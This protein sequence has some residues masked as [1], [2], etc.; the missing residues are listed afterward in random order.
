[1]DEAVQHVLSRDDRFVEKLLNAVTAHFTEEEKYEDFVLTEFCTQLVSIENP[2]EI[3]PIHHSIFWQILKK[4]AAQLPS[5][6][7]HTDFSIIYGNAEQ[8]LHFSYYYGIIVLLATLVHKDLHKMIRHA[9]GIPQVLLVASLQREGLRRFMI[10]KVLVNIE[11]SVNVHKLY[12]GGYINGAVLQD[13]LEQRYRATGEN[14]YETPPP[15]HP[16]WKSKVPPC[17]S[18]G[19]DQAPKFPERAAPTATWLHPIASARQRTMLSAVYSLLWGN[20]ASLILDV[21]AFLKTPDVPHGAKCRCQSRIFNI[22][23]LISLLHA[24]LTQN[25]DTRALS[26]PAMRLLFNSPLF[27]P[28]LSRMETIASNV[29][30]WMVDGSA[31]SLLEMH[32]QQHEVWC[33]TLKHVMTLN[34]PAFSESLSLEN[35]PVEV[36]IT[37]D[38]T[39]LEAPVL[40]WVITEV[41]EWPIQLL[42]DHLD[43]NLSF[44]HW[45]TKLRS[46]LSNKVRSNF[47]AY[48]MEP[49]VTL[50]QLEHSLM[51]L[52]GKYGKIF[53]SLFTTYTV[54]YS[55]GK[56]FL[57]TEPETMNRLRLLLLLESAITPK[58]P[59]RSEFYGN[60]FM[61]HFAAIYAS[62]DARKFAIYCTVCYLAHLIGGKRLRNMVALPSDDIAYEI[63]ELLPR[64]LHLFPDT[65]SSNTRNVMAAF[66]GLKH[67]REIHTSSIDAFLEE[68]EIHHAD[69]KKIREELLR[70]ITK[71]ITGQKV[72]LFFRRKGLPCAWALYRVVLC[73]DYI[74]NDNIKAEILGTVWLAQS[75]IPNKNQVHPGMAYRV[76][77]PN[78][79]WEVDSQ[80]LIHQRNVDIYNKMK[81]RDCHDLSKRTPEELKQ[82]S[83]RHFVVHYE[84]TIKRQAPWTPLLERM[85]ASLL[86]IEW[87]SLGYPD[88]YTRNSVGQL[89]NNQH[90]PSTVFIP[91][92][93]Q[94]ISR[95][96]ICFFE[97]SFM[98]LVNE[99]QWPQQKFYKK[100]LVNAVGDRSVIDNDI[101]STMIMQYNT[102]WEPG[103]TTENTIYEMEQIDY[104]RC[105]KDWQKELK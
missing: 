67:D 94:P 32:I 63:Y 57:V 59:L 38:P 75:K 49:S 69:L 92:L 22:D 56:V 53:P 60:I 40:T 1:M 85:N 104:V 43:I 34:F 54:I 64:L 91:T 72:K 100:G 46:F 14:P 97:D 79:H 65:E 76:Q 98:I 30:S 61:K 28:I 102:D 12:R 48:L 36:I 45:S 41:K 55:A 95:S 24:V 17:L 99:K 31:G 11:D 87:K 44:L 52:H 4:M 20:F 7:T 88:G 29:R 66:L 90:R 78:E 23:F 103:I 19:Y 25:L 42:F 74:Q 3:S 84:G 9:N 21:S 33:Q 35:A 37:R 51:I 81:R 105:V 70:G 71:H 86:A 96:P 47:L 73:G 62:H 5:E 89:Y 101:F 6:N 58:Q 13:L 83:E 68:T 10:N 26:R 93:K 82:L 15:D 80:T 18:N 27:A 2:L 16:E 39:I 50:P 77:C 8:V